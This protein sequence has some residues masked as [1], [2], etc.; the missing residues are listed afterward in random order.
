VSDTAVAVVANASPT[1]VVKAPDEVVLGSPV[2][3]TAAV[4]DRGSLDVLTCQVTWPDGTTES[5]A[6]RGGLCAASRVLDEVGPQ[7]V[8]VA[9]T[10][11]DGGL[12]R[13]ELTVAV[14]YAVVLPE[15]GTVNAGRAIP[16]AFGLGGYRG[17]D[18]LT[19]AVSVRLDSSG[20]PTGAEVA[21]FTPGA[22]DLSWSPGTGNYHWNWDTA[23]E[24]RGQTRALILRFD[25]GSEHR[26]VYAFRP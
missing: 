7:R 8:Q 23:K 6:V 2:S 5:I 11:Q 14:R 17:M 19:E 20:K 18:V 10:D 13:A 21:A 1:V 15:G 24:W 9:V 12:D 16:I 3:L 25:D 22:S 4:S 26:V